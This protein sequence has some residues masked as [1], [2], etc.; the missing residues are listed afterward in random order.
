MFLGLSMFSLVN[1][2]IGESTAWDM[3][4][5]LMVSKNANPTAD[6]IKPANSGEFKGKP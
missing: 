1:P 5:L 4:L 6:I 2:P 3:V